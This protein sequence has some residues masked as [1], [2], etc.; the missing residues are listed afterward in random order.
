MYSTLC[1]SPEGHSFSNSEL[2]ALQVADL[3]PTGDGLRITI[4][5]SKTEQEGQ[6]QDVAIP[7]GVRLRP[8]E[9]VRAWLDAAGIESGPVFRR[10]NKGGR[11]STEG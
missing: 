6:G 11:V 9:A 7:H 2:V 10:V 3:A 4:R 5:R 1:T 8:V